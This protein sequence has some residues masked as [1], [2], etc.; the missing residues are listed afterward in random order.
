MM[1]MKISDF[2]RYALGICAVTALLAGCGALPLDSAQGRLAQGD[3]AGDGMGPLTSGAYKV[4]YSFNAGTDASLP[5]AEDAPL[6][7]SDGL[8]YGTTAEGGGGCGD[9]GCGTVFQASPTGAEHVVYRFKGQPDGQNPTSSLTRLRGTWYGVTAAGGSSGNG[10][11]FAVD[12][13]GHEHVVYSF[14]G[15]SDGAMPFGRLLAFN[16]KLYGTTANGGTSGSSCNENPG[17][18]TVFEVSPTGA[19]SVLYRFKGIPDACNPMAGLIV[20]DGRLYGTT[21]NGGTFGFGS[22]FAITTAG[23]ERVLYSFKYGAKD[24]AG[25]LAP[26]IAVAGKLYGTTTDGGSEGYQGTVFEVSLSGA[27]RVLHRFIKNV[28]DGSYPESALLYRNGE[29][30]GTTDTGGS[31]ACKNAGCGTVFEV[32]TSSGKERVLHFFAGPP[33]GHNPTGGLTAINNTFYGTTYGGGAGSCYSGLGCG[34]V[35]SLEAKGAQ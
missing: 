32:N 34:T 14:K 19:E 26:L 29:L 28:T 33:D 1:G 20:L 7:V 6:V 23:K 11:V 22:V 16:G 27:E 10:S 17:L 4:L 13:S 12:R 21:I 35:F 30:Y 3:K 31:S 9:S 25:P 15:G 18:G 24:G 2:N 5:F 8:L